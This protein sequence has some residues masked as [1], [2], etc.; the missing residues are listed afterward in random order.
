VALVLFDIADEAAYIAAGGRNCCCSSCCSVLWI[1]DGGLVGATATFYRVRPGS[2]RA[3][4]VKI[5]A[6]HD[7]QSPPQWESHF[8]ATGV[9]L[10]HRGNKLL[11]PR[12]LKITMKSHRWQ[13][14]EAS[15]GLSKLKE[16]DDD[17]CHGMTRE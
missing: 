15:R 17:G 2:D 10:G 12:S 7:P 9:N 1:N 11:E 4:M 8:Q 3:V 6:L 14:T 5:F 13:V 16:E